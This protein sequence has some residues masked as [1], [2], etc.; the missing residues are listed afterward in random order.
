MSTVLAWLERR[1]GVRH[2]VKPQ[3]VV[4]CKPGAAERLLWAIAE[5]YCGVQWRRLRAFLADLVRGAGEGGAGDG[6]RG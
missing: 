1:E 4:N 3:E 6:R 5:H 2:G